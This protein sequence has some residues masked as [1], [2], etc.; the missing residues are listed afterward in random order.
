LLISEVLLYGTHK[1][2]GAIFWPWCSGES[3]QIFEIVP[4]SL[5]SGPWTLARRRRGK[6]HRRA[7]DMVL[8]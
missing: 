5:V 8:L 4:Y 3:P 2:V 7:L 6:D 1:I